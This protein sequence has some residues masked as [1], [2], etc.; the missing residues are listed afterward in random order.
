MQRIVTPKV[1][2]LPS[3]SHATVVDGLI[4]ISGTLGT[5][6]GAPQLIDGG[7]AEQTEQAID[8]LCEILAASGGA[9]LRDVVKVS[10]YVVDMADFATVDRVY[11]ARFGDAPP[12]RITLAVAGLALGARVELEAIARRAHV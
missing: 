6:P 11:Q 8:N 7:V 1:G 3:F 12:A 2:R 4:F 10:V 5:K 9:T